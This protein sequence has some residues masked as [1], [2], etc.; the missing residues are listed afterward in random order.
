M[1]AT[2]SDTPRPVANICEKGSLICVHILFYEKWT[3][4]IYLSSVTVNL[5]WIKMK[6]H[7]DDVVWGR[8]GS[9]HWLYLQALIIYAVRSWRWWRRIGWSG[10]EKAA[11]VHGVCHAVVF[12]V[13][14][15]PAT[16][17][18]KLKSYLLINAPPDLSLHY[19]GTFMEFQYFVVWHCQMTEFAGQPAHF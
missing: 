10:E 17:T 8:S 14:I 6:T 19:F 11:C 3:R 5:A 13:A 7:D 2:I 9:C 16:P 1:I 4:F 18:Q 12:P 15:R